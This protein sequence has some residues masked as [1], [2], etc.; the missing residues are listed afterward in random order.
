M[1]RLMGVDKTFL[2]GTPDARPLLR[3]FNLSIE[4]GEFVIL[5]GANGAGK[6]TLFHLLAGTESVD[7]GQIWLDGLEVTARTEPQRAQWISR[8]FQDPRQG[9]AAALTLEENLALAL[10][11]GLPRR[12]KGFRHELSRAV[13]TVKELDMGL[14][15]RLQDPMQL[16]SGGQRQAVTLLM[17]TA[18]RP[19]ILLLDEHTAALDPHAEATILALTERTI[20]AQG[21]TALMITHNL[22]HALRYGTRLIMLRGG[23]IALD[24][25]GEEK[26][27]LRLEELYA[28]FGA[29]ERT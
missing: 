20:A 19:K 9:S 25:T 27:A 15:S 22:S 10:R 14:E 8:V 6:S 17:A 29:E 18:L 23:K 1:I 3:D 24:I 13:A 2:P 26:K 5:L 4:S 16:F 28:K 11:R 12:L 21:L 7:R